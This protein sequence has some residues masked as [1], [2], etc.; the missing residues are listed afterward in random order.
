LIDTVDTSPFVDAHEFAA[1][2]RGELGVLCLAVDS[3]TQTKRNRRSRPADA[4]RRIRFGNCLD[5][6]FAARTG[7]GDKLL[8]GA[9]DKFALGIARGLEECMQACRASRP[10]WPGRTRRARWADAA[11]CTVRTAW[12]RWTGWTRWAG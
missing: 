10:C 1:R 9:T 12:T 7:D 6:D 2:D 3:L 11:A 5:L 8:A 4:R